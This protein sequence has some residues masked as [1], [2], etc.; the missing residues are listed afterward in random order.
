MGKFIKAPFKRSVNFT[1][2]YTVL[3][4]KN[5]VRILNSMEFDV[6]P[7]GQLYKN[8]GNITTSSTSKLAITANS[9]PAVT[10]AGLS[11]GATLGIIGSGGSLPTN[12]TLNPGSTATV[13]VMSGPKI[14]DG[15]ECFDF[16]VSANSAGSRSYA[17]I[18]FPGNFG[19]IDNV[20]FGEAWRVKF[21]VQELSRTGG[22]PFG[23]ACQLGGATSSFGYVKDYSDFT[24]IGSA[25]LLSAN[26]KTIN[27]VIDDVTITRIHGGIYLELNNVGQAASTTFRLSAKVERAE[28]SLGLFTLNSTGTLA[29]KATLSNTIDNFTLSST[30][31]VSTKGVSSNSIGEITL[32][33]VSKLII[34][35]SLDN[36]LD[37]FSLSSTSNLSTLLT[38]G[39]VD[40]TIDNFTLNGVIKYVSIGS[41][42]SIIDNFT[43]EAVLSSDLNGR[44]D[45]SIGDFQLESFSVL[46]INSSLGKTIGNFSL[47]SLVIRK[48][49]KPS[50]GT[51]QIIKRITSGVNIS[52]FKKTSGKRPIR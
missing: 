7:I 24:T 14:V 3:G 45:T 21:Y 5:T 28:N 32:S 6:P 42:D 12:W 52:P 8:I 51:S 46:P 16:K 2:A 15:I 27:A 34:Q 50:S 41:V 22:G 18:Y 23:S 20:K 33:S 9:T 17:L 49:Y 19:S 10:H 4:R 39:V 11:Q 31:L 37:N 47:R 35:S 40:T 13:E 1:G 25:G 30:S 29:V 26:T 43:L 36:T 48:P 38:E 44:V